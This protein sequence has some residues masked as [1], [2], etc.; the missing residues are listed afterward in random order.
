M[1]MIRRKNR[2][3]DFF[4]IPALIIGAMVLAATPSFAEESIKE[5][6]LVDEALVTINNFLSDP[7]MTWFHNNV[8]D[9]KGL[10][11]I[12]ELIKAGFV[13]GTSGG[14]GVFLVRNQK[15]G[16][17]SGPAF[18]M[19][20][21]ISLGFQIGVK[22]SEVVMMV[23]SPKGLKPLYGS[24]FKLGGEASV[25]AGPVGAGAEGATAMNLSA[26]Y[27]SF[28]RSK[29]AFVGLSLEGAY[30]YADGEWN[31]AY[32]GK[33]VKPTD[34]LV[35]GTVNNPHSDKLRRAVEKATQ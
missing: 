3:I 25:A 27:L 26:D 24:S 20:G 18:Y 16:Q 11:I 15:T 14:R 29:G 12:P 9:A 30:V 23:M 19:L 4:L 32:Y 34:I 17:W 13:F 21:S 2:M 1:Q 22:K 31:G 33:L 10:L 8:K 35:S 6:K 5:T 7:D 28:T